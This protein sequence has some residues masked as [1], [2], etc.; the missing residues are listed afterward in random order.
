MPVVKGSERA[1]HERDVEVEKYEKDG[2]REEHEG[3]EH[4]GVEECEEHEKHEKH[5]EHAEDAEA[6]D[7]AC[8]LKDES[9]AHVHKD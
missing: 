8:Q 9:G 2:E 1:R 6:F 3:E 4:G 5:V 7:T